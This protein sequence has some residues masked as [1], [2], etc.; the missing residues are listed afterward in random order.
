MRALTVRDGLTES[1]DDLDAVAVD[2]HGHTLGS[3]GDADRA[4]YY[5]SAIKPIQATVALEAGSAL[6]SEHLAVACASH[7][8]YPIHLAIV[9]AMLNEVGL[10]ERHLGCPPSWP[11]EE[12]ARHLLVAGGQRRPRPLFHNCSGKHASFLRACVAQDWPLRTYLDPD[13]PLQRRIADR[14]ADVSGVPALPEAVDGCGAPGP[15]GTVRG[16]AR[17]YSRLTIDPTYRQATD[18]MSRFGSL[19]SG[20]D[21]IDAAPSRWWGGP[22]KI[23]AE[24]LVGAGRHGIGIAVKSRSGSRRS[25]LVGLME[26]MRLLGALS[27]VAHAALT[28]TARPTVL[29]GGRPHGAVVPEE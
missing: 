22:L 11:L 26:V 6:V 3:W 23:G 16:L 4:L 19:V 27:E 14:V 21:R 15:R 2:E 10:G 12:G 9:R 13:H 28:E 20:A 29:G 8:A 1:T 24:G 18:A 17:I 25:S 5:R 7:S